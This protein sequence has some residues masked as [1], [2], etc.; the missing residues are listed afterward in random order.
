MT[1]TLSGKRDSVDI[2]K[3]L[4]LGSYLGRTKGALHVITHAF[5]REIWLQKQKSTG[6]LKQDAALHALEMEEGG[7]AK[8]SRHCN[9]I[10]RKVK[11]ADSFLKA[12][13]RSVV[14][15]TPWFGLSETDFRPLTSRMLRD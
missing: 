4:E 13:R 5:L 2:I 8:E 14:L 10:A 3:D 15:P 6:A 9:S 12:S 11:D 1:L 7:K